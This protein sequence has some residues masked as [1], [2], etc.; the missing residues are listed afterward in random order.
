[1]RLLHGGGKQGE[2]ILFFQGHVRGS[3]GR[4][5]HPSHVGGED[6]DGDIQ[7]RATQ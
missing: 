1:L 7:V 2:R 3:H 5:L 4:V 6:C